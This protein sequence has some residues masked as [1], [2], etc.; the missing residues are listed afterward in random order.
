MEFK[1]RKLFALPTCLLLSACGG[2]GSSGENSSP[3]ILQAKSLSPNAPYE[4]TLQVDEREAFYQTPASAL[5]RYVVEI[6]NLEQ[7]SKTLKSEIG[8]SKNSGAPSST[9]ISALMIEALGYIPNENESLDI[10]V[11]KLA[12]GSTYNYKV[13]VYSNDV[14]HDETTL[15]PNSHPWIA[16]PIGLGSKIHNYTSASDQVDWYTTPVNA[17]DLI[18]LEIQSDSLSGLSMGFEIDKEV[19]GSLFPLVNGKGFTGSAAFQIIPI[20]YDGALYIKVNGAFRVPSDPEGYTFTLFGNT[21]THD[22]FTFEPNSFPW[23]GYPVQVGAT[24]SS[25]TSGTD[26]ADWYTLDVQDGDS[27]DFEVRSTNLSGVSMGYRFYKKV[28]NEFVPLSSGSGFTGSGKSE[29][30]SID[31]NG[32]LYLRIVGA[33]DVPSSPEGYTFTFR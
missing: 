21:V 23:I 17:G 31:F 12:S 30:I 13:T 10:A 14:E 15:E 18:G 19:D 3:D 4:D 8:G 22:E 32:T 1:P 29:S 6:Q 9:L 27:L 20:D 7:S 5:N 11:S 16:A 2:G 28:G 24:Y 25:Q 33:F 26:Q